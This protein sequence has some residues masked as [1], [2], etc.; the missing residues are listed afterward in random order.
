MQKVSATTN[1]DGT[2]DDAFA[3]V[4]I[5]THGQNYYSVTAKVYNHS[6]ANVTVAAQMNVNE[7]GV[8]D[9]GEG[10]TATVTSS[11]SIQ[12]ISLGWGPIAYIPSWAD[13]VFFRIRVTSASNAMTASNPTGYYSNGEVEDYLLIVSDVLA[14]K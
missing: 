13:S 14:V 12:N 1:G 6:G 2:T 9:P 10:T 11:A 5:F 7:N 8:F 3:V 4:P